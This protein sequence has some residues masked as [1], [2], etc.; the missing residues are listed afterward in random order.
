MFNNRI[1]SVI[2]SVECILYF[3]FT[4]AIGCDQI[5]AVLSQKTQID[6]LQERKKAKNNENVQQSQNDDDGESSVASSIASTSRSR[7]RRLTTRELFA[8]VF[9]DGNLLYSYQIFFSI[10]SGAN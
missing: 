5:T 6:T 3:T 4:I 10:S 2:L 9:G 7:R 8:D 1:H